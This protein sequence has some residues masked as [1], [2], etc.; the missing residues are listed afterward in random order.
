MDVDDGGACPS[1]AFDEST[2]SSVVTVVN[3]EPHERYR[4]DM[5]DPNVIGHMGHVN[6]AEAA[7]IT[8]ATD[9]QPMLSEY[10]ENFDQH[11]H[12]YHHHIQQQYPDNAIRT[13]MPAYHQPH[14]T[15]THNLQS[16][17]SIDDESGTVWWKYSSQ[18]KTKTKKTEQNIREIWTDSSEPNNS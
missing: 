18:K 4:C 10:G 15:S 17:S 16:E 2:G 5:A 6:E 9:A 12:I 14:H 7:V 13:F 3:V 1:N 11:G 8:T